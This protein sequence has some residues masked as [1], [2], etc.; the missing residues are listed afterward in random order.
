MKDNPYPDVPGSKGGKT[1]E[2]AASA[3]SSKTMGRQLG[4][5]KILRQ[6]GDASPETAAREMDLELRCVRPRF[7]ELVHLC[8][9]EWSGGTDLS[10]F[11]L[12]VKKLQLVPELADLDDSALFEALQEARER[13]RTLKKER[14]RRRA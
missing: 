11:G 12:P 1:S 10:D 3:A 9:A 7:S 8:V 13:L 5:L 4:I 2:Y 14:G 6:Y